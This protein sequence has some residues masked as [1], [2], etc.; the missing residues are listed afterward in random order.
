MQPTLEG[1]HLRTQKEHQADLQTQVVPCQTNESVGP[2]ITPNHVNNQ[3]ILFLNNQNCTQLCKIL[4]CLFFTNFYK[5]LFYISAKLHFQ[6][7]QSV[8]FYFQIPLFSLLKYITF[9]FIFI[10][11]CD[12]MKSILLFIK[13][14]NSIFLPQ[15]S[16]F[17]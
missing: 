7:F 2:T 1:H 13:T 3:E 11:I 9:C 12:S 8:I 5:I 4:F 17:K 16:A 6:K 15:N 10:Q 14:L